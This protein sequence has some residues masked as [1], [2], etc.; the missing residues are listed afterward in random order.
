MFVD[1]SALLGTPA[2]VRGFGAA[3]ERMLAELG[4]LRGDEMKAWSR[5]PTTRPKGQ[6]EVKQM[7]PQRGAWACVGVVPPMA[8]AIAARLAVQLK[9]PVQVFTAT[10]RYKREE[11]DRE[12]QAQI[13][14]RTFRPDGSSAVGTFAREVE[15]AAYGDWRGLCDAKSDFL[16]GTLID[17]AVAAWVSSPYEMVT[18]VWSAPA[19]LGDARLD[20]LAQRIRLAVRA[21]LTTIDGRTCVRV[22]TADGERSTSFVTP[23]E[24]ARLEPAVGAL[25]VK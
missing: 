23:D 19:S 22:S 16:I 21:E 4:F 15:E 11:D 14:D 20:E 3:F 12:L 17:G 25:L 2:P 9:A 10:V 1:H 7:T 18:A 24:L 13:E 8:R 5:W 6:L